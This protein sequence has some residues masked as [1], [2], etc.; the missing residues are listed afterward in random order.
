MSAKTVVISAFVIVDSS[1]VSLRALFSRISSPALETRS[2]R[3][4]Y[5]F[6]MTFIFAALSLIARTRCSALL[7]SMRATT[8]LS[9]YSWRPSYVTMKLSIV[10]FTHISGE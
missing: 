10:T 1:K 5:K 9:M 4:S 7:E 2:R 8:M 6:V 3:V